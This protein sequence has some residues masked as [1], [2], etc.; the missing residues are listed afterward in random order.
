M[1]A[2]V[3]SIPNIAAAY[4]A[5]RRGLTEVAV[6]ETIG[7]NVFTLLVTTGIIALISPITIN[8]RWITF[9][10][11]V[12]MWISFLLFIFM[13]SNRGISRK[14]GFILLFSYLMTLFI[15]FLQFT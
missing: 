14:E 1:G 15:Q 2:F 4:K 6:S 8:P 9:D 11:P 3:P 13:S 7:S 12:V 10:I 5:T